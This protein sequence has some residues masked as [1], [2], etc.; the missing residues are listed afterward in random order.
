M[1]CVRGPIC[2]LECH[3]KLLQ[4]GSQILS[5]RTTCIHFKITKLNFKRLNQR[6]VPAI[7]TSIHTWT[8]QHR[9]SFSPEIY[10]T[11]HF[12]LLFSTEHL[13]LWTRYLRENC[14]SHTLQVNGFSPVCLLV[15]RTNA[16]LSLKLNL[17]TAQAKGFSPVCVLLWLFK[18]ACWENL[19]SQSEQANGFSPL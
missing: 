6:A 7:L 10:L 9:V 12:S 4:L 3:I 1:N 19:W 17:Q 14:F 13:C 18:F 11:L 16:E 5:Q 2:L 15:C 8:A